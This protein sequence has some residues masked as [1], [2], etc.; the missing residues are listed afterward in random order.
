MKRTLFFLA[1]YTASFV[2]AIYLFISYGFEAAVLAM[3]S[4]VL[5]WVIVG[6]TE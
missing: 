5:G 4:L 3:L 1:A 2:W 6:R